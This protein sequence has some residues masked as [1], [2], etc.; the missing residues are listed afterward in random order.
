[1]ARKAWEV[2]EDRFKEK[3]YAKI[4]EGDFLLQ[5]HS[6]RNLNLRLPW[7]TIVENGEQIYLSIKFHV[8]TKKRTTCPHCG[9]ETNGPKGQPT[10]WQV[11]QDQ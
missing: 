9:T 11:I 1:M 4:W 6:R 10:F 5:D 7:K 8:D 3:G 2:L